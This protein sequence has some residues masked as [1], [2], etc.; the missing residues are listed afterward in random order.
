M[1]IFLP[2]TP[3]FNAARGIVRRLRAGGHEA[4]FVG[5]CVRDLVRGFAPEEF[6]IVTAARPDRI[7]SLFPRTIPVGAQFGV[8]LVVEDGGRFEVAT[9]RT[10]EAYRD[11]RRPSGVVFATLVEDVR[12]RDFTMNGLVLD[13]ETGRVI[14]LVD[15]LADIGRRLIRT[16]GDPLRRFG[17]DRL[18]MLRAA[19]FS[20][21]LGF[22]VE[23][24]TLAAVR[25]CAPAVG[26][27]SAE[28]IREEMTKLLSRGGARRGMELLSHTGLLGEILPEIQKMI[29]V[30][31]PPAFHPEG[32][33][34]EHTRRMLALLGEGGAAD[35]RLAWGVL[36]HDLG[37][38]FTR[39]EDDRGVHF[40]GHVQKGEELAGRIL[41]RLRFSR[42]D[43]EAILMLIRHHMRF[44]SV[45]R[46]RP[47]RL[48]RFLRMDDF[49]LHL[50]LHRLDCLAS[51]GDLSSYDFCVRKLA[52]IP[53]EALKPPRLV[54]GDDLAAA[55]YAP[56][57]LFGSMLR[58][59]EDAQL[60]GE[61]A[62]RDEAMRWV[63]ERW[64]E[65]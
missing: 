58:G 23:E 16:I 33:V 11:G 30:D 13:P 48:K 52:E 39:S 1:D 42:D 22:A 62:T 45:E 14:D 44:M 43:R 15:G 29:G 65:P 59:V 6:D 18:R 5:G 25:E 20:A 36:F 41:E 60:N 51:H 24:R 53:E 50:E 47:N 56:G 17:E 26:D 35:P 46:M 55:G 10:D 2:D 31:Q 61:I 19:R 34:W 54:T 9:Y 21:N 3:A 7:P 28:R 38:A 57:P 49:P 4:F 32:D 27:V 37:K 40:Y 8:V 63:R 12:R 64:G